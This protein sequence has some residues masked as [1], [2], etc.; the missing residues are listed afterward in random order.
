MPSFKGDGRIKELTELLLEGK[1]TDTEFSELDSLRRAKAKEIT[2]RA[3][4]VSDIKEKIMAFS[5]GVSELFDAREIRKTGSKDGT[6]KTKSP[7]S[8]RKARSQSGVRATDGNPVLIAIHKQAGEV[9]K[10]WFYRR[11]RVYEGATKALKNTPW[12]I[13]EKAF[14]KKLRRV[15]ASEN[16]L[17][18]HFT[19]EGKAYFSTPEGAK[20]LATIVDAVKKAN[21]TLGS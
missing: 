5:I 20:E 21:K 14:P 7:G 8:P 3:A 17:R 9:G 4:T 18:G 15:G 6:Q 2:E 10:D 11:G 12:L 13:S 16:S 19:D 1:I